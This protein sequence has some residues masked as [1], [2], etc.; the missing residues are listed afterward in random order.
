LREIE[1]ICINDGSTDDSLTILHDYASCD[2]RVLLIDQ[3]NQ[4]VASARNNGLQKVTAPYIGFVDSDDFIAP[5]MYEKMYNSMVENE[6]DFV[7]CGAEVI[8]TYERLDKQKDRCFFSTRNLIGKIDNPDAF[9]GTSDTLWKILFKRELI[10][11]NNLEFPEGFNSYEDGLFIRLYKSLLRSGFYIPD[12]LYF[13]FF[14]EN[15]IMGK[16]FTKKQD[17]SVM[18]IF[19]IIELY[20]SFL[21]N[22]GI[23]ERWRNYFWTYFETWINTFYKWADPEIIQTTGIEAIRCLINNEDISRLIDEKNKRY[24]YFLV[25]KNNELLNLKFL[26]EEKLVDIIEIVISGKRKYK[27]VMIKR[28]LSMKKLLKYLLPN[29]IVRIIQKHILLKKLEVAT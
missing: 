15:S 20:Y 6:V 14:Y 21:K 25:L 2:N 16:T 23:F 17:Q 1:I 18:E 27:I 26:N 9:I 8:F 5:D 12:N 3:R 24:Y 10:A 11:K 7:E 22:H 4:G 13:Y 28:K 29:G 19:K